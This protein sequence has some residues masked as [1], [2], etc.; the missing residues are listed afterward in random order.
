MTGFPFLLLA[1]GMSC[2]CYAFKL[3]IFLSDLSAYRAPYRRP[4]GVA[5]T[6]SRGGGCRTTLFEGGLKFLNVY[7]CNAFSLGF[8][9][10]LSR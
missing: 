4:R 3:R 8:F 9:L 10:S 7:G 6:G 1:L 5:T 2:V